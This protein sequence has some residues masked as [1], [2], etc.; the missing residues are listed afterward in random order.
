MS[1]GFSSNK[2]N[3]LYSVKDESEKLT[4]EEMNAYDMYRDVEGKLGMGPDREG[5]PANFEE[6]LMSS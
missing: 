6:L 4:V 1:E 5:L 2:D 3:K